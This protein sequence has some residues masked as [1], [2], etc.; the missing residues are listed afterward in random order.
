[1]VAVVATLCRE[2]VVA[3]SP[4]SHPVA[5]Y[6]ELPHWPI[7]FKL[8]K[9]IVDSW[10]DKATGSILNS[11]KADVLV[12]T[13]PGVK[14]IRAVLLII[15]N[16]DLINIGEHKAI[17]E[18]AAKQEIGII[19]LQQFSGNVIERS[20]PP[21]VADQSFA[22]VLDLAAEK[23]GIAEFRHAPW[24]TLGK[25]SRG[26]FPFRTAWWFPDRVVASINHHGE[27][28][29]WPM[30]SWSKAGKE[31][32]V[33]HLSIQGLSEW[34]G[35]WYRHV[36]P[37]L[38][39]YHRNTGWLGHQMVIYGVD[40]GY[41]ADYYLY[42]NFGK[43]MD[44]NH[45][46]ARCTDVWNYIALFIDKAMERR[47]PKNE[48]P[49]EKPT[50]LVAVKRDSGYLI[51][52][53][54]PEEL[55]ATKWFALRKNKDGVYQSIPWPEEATPVLDTTQGTIQVTELIRPASEVPADQQGDYLW[56]ADKDLARAWLKLHNIYG[57]A[58]KVL[59]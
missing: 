13:P 21:T 28:P 35:T 46:L 4:E 55:L 49:T 33:M 43:P 6:A 44:K 15:N 57:L 39:N 10:N 11:P 52:A 1:M 29:T 3:T 14:H 20:D 45:R 30:P 59:P 18:V 8:P 2:T 41:Y 26:R 37:S 48:Y 25:S 16:T 40:H 51:H 53:R 17:R 27:V 7:G 34:D 9:D 54:A 58:D 50:A 12:W 47:V 42:P 22:A 32:T 19:Y 36:R 5:D 24:I 23:T 31:E 38:L 56:I